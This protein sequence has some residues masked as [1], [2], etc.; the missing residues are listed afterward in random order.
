MTLLVSNAL[1]KTGNA[2][3][4][5]LCGISSFPLSWVLKYDEVKS[6]LDTG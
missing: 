2:L 6:T 1:A 4:K 5:T 3:A